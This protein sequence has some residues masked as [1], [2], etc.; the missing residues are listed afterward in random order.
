MEFLPL[1]IKELRVE[2][3]EYNSI[4]FIKPKEFTF[5]LGECFSFRFPGEENAKI[6]SFASSPTEDT[7]IISYKKGISI[8]KKRLESLRVGDVM[9]V[10]LFG[11][12]FHFLSHKPALFIAGG[13]G[14]TAFRSIIAYCMD[15]EISTSLHLLFINRTEAFP[16]RQEFASFQKNNPHL[17]ITYHAT[18]LQGRVTKEVLQNVLPSSTFD[19]YLAGPPLMIDSMVDLL[20]SC[21]VLAKHIHTE[22][23]DGYSEEI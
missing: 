16:F 11:S 2:T 15:K 3:E 20:R 22:S 19:A 4:I 10:A 8:F 6:F 21:G 5:I 23:F 18:S 12:Q 17:S 14:I 1:T 7:I 13:I 9:E